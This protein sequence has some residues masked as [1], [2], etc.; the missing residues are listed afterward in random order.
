MHHIGTQKGRAFLPLPLPPQYE[1][2]MTCSNP[3]PYFS[4]LS[5][6][7]CDAYGG[8]WCPNPTDCSALQSCIADDKVWATAEQR[9]A[10]VQYLGDA[11][12]ITNPRDSDE[13]GKTREYFG[14]D[15]FF[16]ND[17][18]ICDD[19][20]QLRYSRDFSFLDDFFAQG[21]GNN[22]NNDIMND[23]VVVPIVPPFEPTAVDTGK[24]K[25]KLS[26]RLLLLFS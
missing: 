24:T 25:Y 20:Y 10:F 7:S 1:C 3:G 12:L 19:I 26:H 16:L 6:E 8:T 15:A 21:S 4:G 18:Q 5:V 13:C 22:N 9:A 17:V 14:Y 2:S 11:P 23:N